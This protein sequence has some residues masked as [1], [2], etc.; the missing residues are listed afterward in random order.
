MRVSEGLSEVDRLQAALLES[1][2]LRDAFSRQVCVNPK[3]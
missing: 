3:P 2:T 1:E